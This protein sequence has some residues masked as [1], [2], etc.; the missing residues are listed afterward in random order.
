MVVSG[1][2][3]TNQTVHSSSQQVKPRPAEPSML[4]S[5]VKALALAVL[6]ETPTVFGNTMPARSMAL[7]ADQTGR[8][9]P[10]SI[11]P[12]C[13]TT[14]QNHL[15]PVAYVEGMGFAPPR[16]T[17]RPDYTVSASYDLNRPAEIILGKIGNSTH[18]EFYQ[19]RMPFIFPSEF[20]PT[21]L[22]LADGMPIPTSEGDFLVPISLTRFDLRSFSTTGREIDGSEFG[23]FSPNSVKDTTLSLPSTL[24]RHLNWDNLNQAQNTLDLKYGAVKMRFVFAKE[25]P[26]GKSFKGLVDGAEAYLFKRGFGYASEPALLGNGER[27]FH[28]QQYRKPSLVENEL[29]RTQRAALTTNALPYCGPVRCSPIEPDFDQIM[30]LW[31]NGDSTNRQDS[32][33]NVD[34]K[35][36]EKASNSDFCLDLKASETQV[37]TYP[38]SYFYS[39]IHDIK[40]AL[41]GDIESLYVSVIDD[42]LLIIGKRKPLYPSEEGVVVI[43][44]GIKPYCLAALPKLSK[45]GIGFDDLNKLKIQYEAGVV[46]IRFKP[47]P[48]APVS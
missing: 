42:T 25:L 35:T 32:K 34:T 19:G 29:K 12:F 5:V 28:R 47:I 14:I 24:L 4:W 17:E 41:A 23:V 22:T 8:F 10:T 44:Q 3:Q 30:A 33:L 38:S 15:R 2:S 6:F 43:H 13:P 46:S 36:F 40:F 16:F 37:H 31:I 20:N 9:Q 21:H 27:L 7:S 11:V 48:K 26:D 45:H 18:T 39:H 1:I